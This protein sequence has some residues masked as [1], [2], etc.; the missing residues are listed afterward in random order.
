MQNRRLLLALILSS[1][2]LALWTW[3]Y[4]VKPPS[5]QQQSA[6]ATPSPS[7]TVTTAPAPAT[8]PSA[9]S[10]A[11]AQAPQR[12]ITIKTD[13][14][15]AKFDT[16]GAEPISW[17]IKKNKYS[18]SPIYSV[19]GRK[20]DAKPLELISPEGLSRQPRV[21]PLQL[22]T[23]DAG[24]DSLLASTTYRVEGIDASSGD[25]VL[26]LADHEK[27]QLTFVLEDASGLQVRK[28][29]SFDNDHYEADLSLVVK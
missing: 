6:T 12:T 29:L 25:A 2:I 26:T 18:G 20:S 13:L 1:A 11:I 28:T 16:R 7:P 5:N 9:A 10:P 22:Q 17:V 14:Y 15:E 27:K 8:A 19:A 24:V 3:F 23:G 21:V 4:P